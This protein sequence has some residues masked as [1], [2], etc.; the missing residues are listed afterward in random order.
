MTIPAAK[1]LPAEDYALIRN[2]LCGIMARAQLTVIQAMARVERSQL[3]YWSDLAYDQ[4]A[5]S[6]FKLRQIISDQGPRARG[7]LAEWGREQGIA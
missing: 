3:G 1:V 5:E 2:R 7:A 4:G 6:A